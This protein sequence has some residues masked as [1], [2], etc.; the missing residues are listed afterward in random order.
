MDLTAIATA[1]LTG[2]AA[3]AVASLIAPWSQWGVEKKK[4]LHN[5]R[6]KKIK[7]WNVMIKKIIDEDIDPTDVDGYYELRD[8]LKETEIKIIEEPK[9]KINNVIKIPQPR[10]LKSSQEASI[11]FEGIKR[12]KKKWKME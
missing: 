12:A 6:V 1:A 9:L 4:L 3:G 2:T 10:G 11:L 7:A 5:D 8:F